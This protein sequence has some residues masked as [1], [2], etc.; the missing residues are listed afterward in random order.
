MSELKFFLLT[1]V[2]TPDPS[3]QIKGDVIHNH[4]QKEKV[5]KSANPRFYVQKKLHFSC[6]F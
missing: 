3:G 6:I 1:G 5:K 4:E 2:L